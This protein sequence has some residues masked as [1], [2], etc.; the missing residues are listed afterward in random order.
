MRLQTFERD[1]RWRPGIV[2]NGEVIDIAA[3]WDPAHGR[4]PST[5]E[6]LVEAFETVAPR[7]LEMVDSPTAVR[8]AARDLRIGPALPRPGK[9]LCVGLN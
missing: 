6:V 2:V 3:S 7:L 8:H 4:S 1:G 9:I 5:M